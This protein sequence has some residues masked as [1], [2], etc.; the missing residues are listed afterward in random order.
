MDSCEDK[1]RKKPLQSL[2]RAF[3]RYYTIKTQGTKPPFAA[4]AEFHS[5]N[6]QYFLTRAAKIADIDS[7]EFVFFAEEKHLDAA[8]LAIL[9]AAAWEGGLSRVQP[10]E[11]HRNSDV[12]LIIVADSLDSD[13]PRAV[14]KARHSASYRFGLWGWSN[15]RILAY[16]VS[17]GKALTNRLGAPL[18]KYVCN[19]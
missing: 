19:V 3:E 7:H 5:H 16:D 14:K 17:S 6:E 1:D 18:K 2:L 12:T 13:I 8:R 9:D 4:E 10:C 11:G 15:Y